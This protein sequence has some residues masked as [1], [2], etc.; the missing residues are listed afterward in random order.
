[1]RSPLPWVHHRQNGTDIGCEKT[2][3]PRREDGMK[4][5]Q[6]P[7]PSVNVTDTTVSRAGRRGIVKAGLSWGHARCVGTLDVAAL[8]EGTRTSGL[9]SPFR[10]LTNG[11]LT[12]QA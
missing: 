12:T 5:G 6:V 1:M 8:K 4:A 9:E 7:L 2:R 3:I 10:P 11:M